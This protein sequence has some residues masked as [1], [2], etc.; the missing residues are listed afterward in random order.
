[1]IPSLS[2]SWTQ[3]IESASFQIDTGRISFIA[4]RCPVSSSIPRFEAFA[5]LK[6][7]RAESVL[8]INSRGLGS[9]AILIWCDLALS[10]SSA[11]RE[12][13]LC[14]TDFH[15]DCGMKETLVDGPPG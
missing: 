6:S 14:Q 4:K 12:T 2:L 8:L 5:S 3:I 10:H 11:T 7:D 1:M 13:Y 15:S 9:T